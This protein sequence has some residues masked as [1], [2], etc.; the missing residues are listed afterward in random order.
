MCKCIMQAPNAKQDPFTRLP[1]QLSYSL[2]T[3]S[4]LRDLKQ[5]QHRIVPNT[6]IGEF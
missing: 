5:D 2:S 6:D 4:E 3:L 1:S